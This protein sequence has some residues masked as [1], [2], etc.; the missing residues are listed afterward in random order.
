M[1]RDEAFR[2]VRIA[3]GAP[4][5]WA[6][7]PVMRE[8]FHARLDGSSISVCPV[9]A[10][11]LAKIAGDEEVEDRSN[12]P[13]TCLDCQELVRRLPLRALARSC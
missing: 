12:H 10:K 8:L 6:V 13:R 5:S 9:G 11:V 4:V 3:D 7:S 1:R 2:F